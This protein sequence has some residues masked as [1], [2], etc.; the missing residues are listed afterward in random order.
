MM[1]LAPYLFFDGQCEAAFTDY[2]RI[3]GGRIEAMLRYEG[4]PVDIAPEWRSKIMHACLELDDG[5]MLMASDAPPEQSTGPMQSVH[6]SVTVK[7]PAEAE[8]IFAALA[9]GG[10]VTMPMAETFWAPRFGMLSDRYGA[11]WMVGCE[12]ATG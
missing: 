12:P 7:E 4:S 10:T 2:Q 11:F 5:Q 8:R 9:E 3:L 1:K 6:V